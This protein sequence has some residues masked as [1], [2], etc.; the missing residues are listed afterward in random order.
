MD[1]NYFKSS[2]APFAAKVQPQLKRFGGAVASWDESALTLPLTEA[3]SARAHARLSGA[4]AIPNNGDAR[5]RWRLVYLG[6]A[7]GSGNSDVWT[8]AASTDLENVCH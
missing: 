8:T 3:L 2:N 1:G 7:V 4:V 6:L 5:Y